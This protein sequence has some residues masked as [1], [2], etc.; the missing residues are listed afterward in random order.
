[1]P[2][3][4]H[5]CNMAGPQANHL[6]EFN[7]FVLLYYRWGNGKHEAQINVKRKYSLLLATVKVSSMLLRIE[8]SWKI[9]NTITP[10]KTVW[11]IILQN[12]HITSHLVKYR[13]WKWK[14]YYSPKWIRPFDVIDFALNTEDI[15]TFVMLTYYNRIFFISTHL[16]SAHLHW[17]QSIYVCGIRWGPQERH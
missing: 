16:W 17:A 11:M 4:V 5:T 3:S 12:S 8:W 14:K 9:T 7:N 6:N 10:Q 1:M 15:T 13:E 2:F